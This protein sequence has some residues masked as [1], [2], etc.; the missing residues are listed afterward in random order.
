[1]HIKHL[2]ELCRRAV[3]AWVDD[4]APSMGAAHLLLHHVLAGAAAGD[5][6]RD[7]RRGVRPRGGAGADLR[8]S[9]RADR[10]E[11]ATAVQAMLKAASDTDQG[12]GRRADQRR[13]CCWSARPRSSP[14]CRARSTA[15]GTC[16]RSAEA[17]G[18]L[19]ASCAPGC[20]RSA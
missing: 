14:S 17:V 20:C 7:G 12:P 19:G 4:Y 16:P 2:Y 18:R 1:M 5:R 11:G 6:D 8:R 10:R 9:W 13:S 3:M 15:S